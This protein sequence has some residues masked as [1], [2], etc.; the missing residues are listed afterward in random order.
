MLSRRNF[1]KG[2]L[3]SSGAAVATLT[4]VRPAL[5]TT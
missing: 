3:A 1:L 2:C 5:A 4:P